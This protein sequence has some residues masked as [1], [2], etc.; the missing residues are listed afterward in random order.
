MTVGFRDAAVVR[1]HEVQL[2]AAVA[3]GSQAGRLVFDDQ[4]VRA[5]CPALQEWK[6]VL[7][8]DDAVAGRARAGGGERGGEDVHGDGEAVEHLARR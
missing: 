7:A 1:G 2:P 8:V 6:E 4:V 5:A 3:H